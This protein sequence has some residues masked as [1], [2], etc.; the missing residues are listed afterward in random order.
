MTI[1]GPTEP[2]LNPEIKSI[3]KVV[4]KLRNI[5]L[6]K[7]EIDLFTNASRPID[8]PPVDKI[9][10]KFD[11]GFNKLEKPKDKTTKSDVIQNIIQAKIKPK[12]IQSMWCDGTVGNYS[13]KY[14]QEYIKNLNIIHQ[15]SPIDLLQVYTILYIPFK[16]FINQMIPCS[17]EK[18][19]KLAR[20]I[21]NE[22]KI[23]TKVFFKPPQINKK[24]IF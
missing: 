17:K 22:T 14:I 5:Y 2:L 7:T 21:A 12:I 4:T 10:L 19:N 9:F 13:E 23:S 11:A 3:I 6:P 8:V 16:H 1:C 18:L 20:K 15:R 24:I